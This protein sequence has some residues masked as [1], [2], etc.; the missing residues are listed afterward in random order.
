MVGGGRGASAASLFFRCA[1]YFSVSPE[2]NIGTTQE[3][4]GNIVGKNSGF[5]SLS[6]RP[7]SAVVQWDGKG[8]VEEWGV[9]VRVGL[10]FAYL[11]IPPS[12]VR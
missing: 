6:L 5:C 2:K 3:K 9:G 4:R 10:L 12:T 11:C 1:P 7:S 8:R